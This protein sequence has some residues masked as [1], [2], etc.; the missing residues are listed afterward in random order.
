MNSDVEQLYTASRSERTQFNEFLSRYIFMAM[1]LISSIDN[2][3]SLATVR[4]WVHEPMKVYT[5]YQGV[6][7]LQPAG[8]SCPLEGAL[9][10][11]MAPRTPVQT[12]PEVTLLTTEE[13]YSSKVL[14]ALPIVP[15]GTTQEYGA[16][17]TDEGFSMYTPFGEIS[18]SSTGMGITYNGEQGKASVVISPEGEVAFTNNAIWAKLTPESKLSITAE[19]EEL[20]TKIDFEADSIE[21]KTVRIENDEETVLSSVA[22]DNQGVLTVVAA[23][24]NTVTINNNGAEIVDINGNTVQMT[25]DGINITDANDNKIET[26]SS[27]VTLTDVN[28]NKIETSSSGITLTGAMGSVEIQ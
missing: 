23:E 11:L 27:G 21:I 10:L 12:I 24:K 20:T 5:E 9:C 3:T 1:G 19:G 14:K 8:I 18:V 28:D 7:I 2:E 25:G 4:T 17:T 6:E 15:F 13:A 26:S 22:T 16:G